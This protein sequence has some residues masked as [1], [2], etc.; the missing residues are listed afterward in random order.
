MDRGL[1]REVRENGAP[2]PGISAWDRYIRQRSTWKIN[3]SHFYE[4]GS[5]APRH[6]DDK[7]NGDT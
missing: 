4:G 6:T 7:E 5:S 3:P 1:A 2:E